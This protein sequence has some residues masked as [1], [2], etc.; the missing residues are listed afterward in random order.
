VPYSTPGSATVHKVHATPQ[1]G[2]IKFKLGFLHT[3][4]SLPPVF[5]QLAGELIP[6]TEVFHIV[7]ES[8]LTATRESGSLTTLTKRRLFGHVASAVD[9]GADMVVV[10]CSSMGP[11]V[12]IIHDLVDVPVLRVDEPMADEAVRLGT[13]IGVL[14][15]LPTTLEPTVELV[16]RR[17]QHAGKRVKVVPSLCT[18]AFD[19]LMAGEQDLHDSLVLEG[20]RK[21]A[22]QS[23]VVVLAQ[24]SMARVTA[25]LDD[26]ERSVPILSSPR[27]AMERVAQLLPK[28]R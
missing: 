28:Q 18:G 26:D 4:L 24:A 8:L 5:T 20:F 2:P 10:T 1:S 12:D 16:A 17:G 11:G 19:A 3:V 9:A 14:A 23:E 21:L 25:G 6:G 15:T 13:V 7:D 27:L 22:E